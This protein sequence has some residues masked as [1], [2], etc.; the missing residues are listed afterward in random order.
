MGMV[1]DLGATKA[2]SR[3]GEIPGL[4]DSQRELLDMLEKK[5]ATV[6]ERLSPVMSPLTPPAPTSEKQSDMK[7]ECG[8]ALRRAN[9]RLADTLDALGRVLDALEV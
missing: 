1:N 4:M 5:V 8:K 9:A 3:T 7:T 6:V 2:S